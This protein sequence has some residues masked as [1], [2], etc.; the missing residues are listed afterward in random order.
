MRRLSL[1]LP[2]ISI[3]FAM[4]QSEL[5]VRKELEEVEKLLVEVENEVNA[6]LNKQS[7]LEQ[8]KKSLKSHL[9][10]LAEQKNSAHSWGTESFDWSVELETK[11]RSVFGISSFRSHQLEVMNVTLSGVDCILIMPTGAGKSL[12]FQLPA[13]ISSGLTLVISPLVSLME[14]QISSLSKR[15]V[16]AVMLSSSTEKHTMNAVFAD[17]TSSPCKMKLLYVTPEKLAKSKRFMNKLEQCYKKGLLSRIAIDEVHCCSHWGHDFRPDY[18]FL[19]ILKRQ[20]PQ[21]PIL[22]LT[23]TASMHVLVDVQKILHLQHAQVYKGSFNRENL[24]YQVQLKPLDHTECM[25]KISQLILSKYRNQS[26]IV[27]CFSRKDTVSVASDLSA[28]GVMSAAYHADLESCERSRVHNLWTEDKIKVIV[29]TI[30]FGMGIDKPNVRFVI[31]HSLSKSVE[32][33]YQE[34]GRAGRD[35]LP[36]DCLLLYRLSDVHRQS[37]MVFTESTGLAQLYSMMGYC[38][39]LSTC[40]RK[41]L[42]QHFNEVWEETSCSGMCDCCSSQFVDI[43]EPISVERLEKSIPLVYEVLDNAKHSDTRLTSQKVLNAVLGKGPSQHRAHKAADLSREHCEYLVAKML[44][45]GHIKEE[46]HFTP[47]STI[48]YLVI[49]S[50]KSNLN[51]S[52]NKSD[53]EKCSPVVPHKRSKMSLEEDTEVILLSD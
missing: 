49:A 28:R 6:L 36:A 1:W 42:A 15:N 22:G 46:F 11:C 34:S 13:L 4:A 17:M 44:A 19:G 18:K 10:R 32:N 29:A 20:F 5:T 8:K 50:R 25:D 31:H 39:N 9:R 40:R 23:A 27:Y 3:K 51:H 47:Y 48:S 33:Y 38:C 43:L 45:A 21:T 35:G 41:L 16:N 14:D 53:S 24:C 2:S 30:A 37:C 26:G 7:S 52:E 12:C